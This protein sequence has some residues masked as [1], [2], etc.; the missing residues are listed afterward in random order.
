MQSLFSCT[1]RWTTL[2]YV[3]PETRSISL[4]QSGS[5]HNAVN[6]AYNTLLATIAYVEN[7]EAPTGLLGDGAVVQ[8]LG[9][10]RMSPCVSSLSHCCS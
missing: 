10:L 5:T 6:G 2:R 9:D 1:C 4:S 8:W 3:A 7:A